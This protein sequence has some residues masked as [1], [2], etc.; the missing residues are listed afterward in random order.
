MRRWSPLSSAATC[1]ALA[2]A[3]APTLAADADADAR[4]IAEKV[5]T[6]GAA[7]F[8]TFDARAMA[9]TYA[10]DAVL[11]L[12]EKKDGKVVRDVREGRAAIEAAYAEVFKNPETVKSRNMVD[13]ARLVSHDVLTID[14]TFDIN[15][16]KPD[17]VKVPFHQVRRAKDGKWAIASM[18]IYL[19]PAD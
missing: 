17:S 4:K 2:L 19:L 12:F 10:E 18:E 1:L 6:E 7:L 5:T 13:R 16:L 14:G 8:D 15:T 3:A 9:A 11:I